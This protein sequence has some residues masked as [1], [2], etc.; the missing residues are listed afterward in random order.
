MLLL[1][2]LICM[3][4]FCVWP[5]FII[6]VFII[7]GGWRTHVMCDLQKRSPLYHP[8][9]CIMTMVMLMMRITVR[10]PTRAT[11][12]REKSCHLA[13][14]F[15]VGLRHSG[16]R[17]RRS[18][19]WNFHA[20]G[21]KNIVSCESYTTFKWTTPELQH[22]SL[23]CHNLCKKRSLQRLQSEKPAI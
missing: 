9:L 1:L 23:T 12:T 14:L 11:M 5:T 18:P 13:S 15:P 20:S 10:T 6:F 4:A 21:Q 16:V 17:P 19:N 2:S 7:R 22:T 3:C 8:L